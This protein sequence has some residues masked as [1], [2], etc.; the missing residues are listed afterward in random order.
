MTGLSDQKTWFRGEREVDFYDIKGAA[1]AFLTAL[2]LDGFLFKRDNIPPH[3][4]PEVSS[5]IHFS[6]AVIGHVGQILPKVMKS[7]DLESVVA[8]VFE[9]DIETLLERMP[10]RKAFEPY[11][12]FPAVFRDISLIVRRGVASAEVQEIIESEGGELIEAVDLYDFYEGG[13][14]DPSE[15]ALTFRVCYRSKEGTLD[16][17][18]INRLNETIINQIRQRTGGRLREG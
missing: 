1:Q 6:D 9:V 11:A 7:Y 5:Q 2:G 13:K 17:Q 3:Y 12:R 15:K 4:H 10:D 16:G 18:E 14:I 8:Y